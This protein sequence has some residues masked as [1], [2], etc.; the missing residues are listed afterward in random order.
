MLPTSKTPPKICWSELTTLIYGP[1]KIGKSTWCSHTPD[2]LFLATEPGLNALEVFQVP[3]CSW[4]DI[5][6]AFVEIRAGKHDFRTIVIDTIDN[7][8]KMCVE[9]VCKDLKIQYLA[10]APYGKGFAAVQDRFEKFLTAL[11]RLPYGL[12]MIS[13]SCEKELET[14]LGKQHMTVPTLPDKAR[15]LVGALADMILYCDIVPERDENNRITFPR[16]MFTK[17]NA[18]FEAGDRTGRLPECLPLDYQAFEAAF[19][20]ETKGEPE[21]D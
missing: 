14:R 15:T 10:D 4:E 16:K 8:Y 7:A 21:N 1:P 9:A 13:H 5:Q 12:V 17:P 6:R 3:V 2:S 11:A 20:R 19:N 18:R